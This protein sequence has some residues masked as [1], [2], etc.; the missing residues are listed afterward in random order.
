MAL[1]NVQWTGLKAIGVMMDTLP[2]KIAGKR[3]RESYRYALKPTKDAMLNNI[4][5]DR[6]G[7]L[8]YSI[9]T[10]IGGGQ[11]LKEMFGV[12]GPRR[13]RNVWNMQGWHA[14]IIEDGT[15]AHKI[16][17]GRLTSVFGAKKMPV[18][19]KAGFT[20]QYVRQLSHGGSR[21]YKPFRKALDGSW[22]KVADRVSDKVAEIMRIEIKEI[23]AKY[24]KVVT[25]SDL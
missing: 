15:K 19:T 2:D 11:Q 8:K 18:W 16:P 1:S 23:N 4:P 22:T 12:I 14:H 25:K 10:T 13:K 21:G 17:K 24:G 9:D 3:L 6:T 7:R 5:S 20:G